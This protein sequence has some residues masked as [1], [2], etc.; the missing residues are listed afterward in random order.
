MPLAVWKQSH[1]PIVGMIHLPPLPGAPRNELRLARIRDLALEDAEALLSG[2]IQGL[3]V[4]NF[5]DTPFFPAHVPAATI[6]QMT[7]LLAEIKRLAG[8]VP[9]GVNVL[10]N[11]G[12]AALAVA[13]AAGGEFIR[14][15]ILSGARVTDQGIVQGNAH[16]LLRE[17][18]RLN[19]EQI[20]IW[21][22][23]EVKHS[24]PVAPR[25]LAD[26]VADLVHRAHADALI[27]T[28]RS[29]GAAIEL[30]DL[31]EAK[32]AAEGKP[33]IVGSGVTAATVGSLRRIASGAIVGSALKVG[34]RATN[35]VDTARVRELMQAV[36]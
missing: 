13:A 4:E 21:A 7:W 29:T 35:R 18:R 3:M 17:R 32:S 23:V 2:G 28:G 24:A 36:A 12:L 8:N 26:E 34:G 31:K 10:R 9:C 15:N 22:D 14:V 30:S 11:D 33:V 16:E 1:L 27:V 20:Q 25:P 6:A 5:G 19:A